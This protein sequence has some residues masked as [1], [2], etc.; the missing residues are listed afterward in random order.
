MNDTEKRAW[1]IH[2]ND[3]KVTFLFSQIEHDV[4]TFT[5]DQPHIEDRKDWMTDAYT[6]RGAMTKL[7][8]QRGSVEDAGFFYCYY[9]YFSSLNISIVIH[10]SGNGVPEE[11]VA[12]ALL[13]LAFEKG[14]QSGFSKNKVNIKDIPSILLAESYADYLKISEA[15]TAGF[16]PDWENKLPW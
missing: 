1:L 2:F 4:P 16:S 15:C 14:R 10:F 3:Y 7:G 9:K 13:E 11:N 8:Y 6:L 12:V 5:K